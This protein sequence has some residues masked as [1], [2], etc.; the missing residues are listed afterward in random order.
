LRGTGGRFHAISGYTGLHHR[1][2]SPID[3]RNGHRSSRQNAIQCAWQWEMILSLGKHSNSIFPL[4]NLLIYH[5]ATKDRFTP[6]SFSRSL[7]TLPSCMPEHNCEK[8]WRFLKS[9]L[10]SGISSIHPEGIEI[11]K[12]TSP[13]DI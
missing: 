2:P 9:C 7:V 4:F 12:S 10:V 11:F 3:K 6:F 8:K 13:S 1:L 5:I